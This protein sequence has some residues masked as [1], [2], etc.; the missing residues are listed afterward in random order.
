MASV[1]IRKAAIRHLK[2][3]MADYDAHDVECDKC[4][5]NEFIALMSMSARDSWD[6]CR[7]WGNAMAMQWL[8]K[9]LK[10]NIVVWGKIEFMTHLPITQSFDTSG[11]SNPTIDIAHLKGSLVIMNQSEGYTM[12]HFM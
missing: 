10:L 7:S 5:L 9:A 8:A 1:K 12:L 6:K 2:A 4:S 3:C 11:N